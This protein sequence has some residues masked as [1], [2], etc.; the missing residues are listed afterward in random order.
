MQGSV[1][2]GQVF[3]F[4]LLWRPLS[5]TLCL[6]CTKC[7]YQNMSLYPNLAQVPLY[8]P[9][10]RNEKLAFL[11]RS[12]DWD[13]RFPKYH[14]TLSPAIPPK[15]QIWHFW[16]DLNFRSSDM[17]TLLPPPPLKMQI[18]HFWTDLDFRSI[19]S[20]NMKTQNWYFWTDLDSRSSDLK[21][22]TLPPPP[23][24]P[25]MEIHHFWVD[26]NFRT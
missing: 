26:L 17:K 5:S 15:M 11:D 16:T 20:W 14:F 12:W 3:L 1:K 18:W 6:P 19:Q 2:C 8:L 10:Y 22:A 9:P 4:S 13:F 7:K 23:P 24:T 21:S 25:R